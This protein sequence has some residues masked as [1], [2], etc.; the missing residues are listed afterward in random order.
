MKIVSSCWK[1]S[2]KTRW[3]HWSPAI[4]SMFKGRYEITELALAQ[5]ISLKEEA[6]FQ[7]YYLRCQSILE[8]AWPACVEAFSDASL[9]GGLF[10]IHSGRKARRH[11][12]YT[13]TAFDRAT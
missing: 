6:A 11:D 8:L 13:P 5:R 7:V 1:A 3:Q 12:E 2:V 4:N 10:Q 9:V